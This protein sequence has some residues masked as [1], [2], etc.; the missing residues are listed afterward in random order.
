MFNCLPR[1]FTKPNPFTDITYTEHRELIIN[2][3]ADLSL[4][5]KLFS[6]T[7]TLQKYESIHPTNPPDF[8][9]KLRAT[10]ICKHLLRELINDTHL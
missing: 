10:T 4:S 2:S 3:I 1:N 7:A 9:E 6:L 8:Y 5:G